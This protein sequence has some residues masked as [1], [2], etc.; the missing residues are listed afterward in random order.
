[1]TA[2]KN[3]TRNDIPQSP[4]GRVVKYLR[5]NPIEGL[6]TPLRG[7]PPS[8]WVLVPAFAVCT[9]VIGFWRD[10]FELG[11]AEPLRFLWLPVLL[12]V[13]PT[14]VEE[15]F[16]RGILLP[17]SLRNASASRRFLAVTASTALYVAAHPL[18]PLLG[19][20]DFDFFLDPWILLVVGILGYTCGYSYLRSGSL[21]A[22]MLI[23]WGTVLVWNLFLG[24][25]YS[26]LH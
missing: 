19:L 6:L 2:V 24:G 8:T 23:H 21:R 3:P 4:I 9:L 16:Y 20:T 17:R 13:F 18:S 15:F 26:G 11:L 12:V 7:A 14:L 22:P 1:M 10:Q 5:D 25:V